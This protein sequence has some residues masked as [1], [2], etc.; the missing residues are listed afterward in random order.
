MEKKTKKNEHKR[1]FLPITQWFENGSRRKTIALSQRT[2]E[3]PMF[4]TLL[5]PVTVTARSNIMK[6]L[7][8]HIYIICSFP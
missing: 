5:G 1:E 2:A 7:W 8:C 3:N 4:P 6:L